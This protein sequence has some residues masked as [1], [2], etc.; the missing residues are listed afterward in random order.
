MN[1]EH[2]AC[3]A[4]GQKVVVTGATGFVGRFLVEELSRRQMKVI[5]LNLRNGWDLS[6]WERLKQ[7]PLQDVSFVYHLAGRLYVPNSLKN[8][9]VFFRA[10]VIGTINLLRLCRLH[11]IKKLVFMSTSGVYGNPRILPINENHPLDPS[12]PYAISKLLAEQLCKIF[13][14]DFGLQFVIFRA[15]NIYGPGQ[16]GDLLIPKILRQLPQGR[17]ELFDPEP[18]RDFLYVEDAVR[19]LWKAGNYRG[20]PWEIFNLGSGKSYS[21][22]E[23]V[24][25]I[26]RLSGKSEIPVDYVGGRRS[27]EIMETKADI[28]HAATLLDWKPRVSLTN[29]LRNCLRY[30]KLMN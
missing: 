14:E 24:D 16:S 12:G 20:G 27:H 1:L 15:F 13:F 2:H 21:V 23:I 25:E 18:K 10:N 8:P 28:Q 22:E 11:N 5:P 6:R 17:V 4:A 7:F 30:N 9:W 26:L 29:G 19:A 3:L